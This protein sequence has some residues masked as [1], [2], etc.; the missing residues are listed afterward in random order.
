MWGLHNFYRRTHTV[1]IY[2]ADYHT[3]SLTTKKAKK[4]KYCH[5]EIFL[6]VSEFSSLPSYVIGMVVFLCIANPAFLRGLVPVNAPTRLRVSWCTWHLILGWTASKFGIV[7][8]PINF[9]EEM[10]AQKCILHHQHVL[11]KWRRILRDILK[12]C[13]LL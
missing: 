13:P 6:R 7:C 9:I 3:I 11:G 1:L 4:R 5:I 8:W 2:Y 12:F 10:N